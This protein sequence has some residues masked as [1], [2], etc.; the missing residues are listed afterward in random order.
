MGLSEL[1]VNVV[2]KQVFEQIRALELS[3]KWWF[4]GAVLALC[5]ALD[6]AALFYQHVLDLLPCELCIY[7]RVWLAALGLLALLAMYACR[8]PWPR[9]F[10]SLTAL[11]LAIGLA[12]ESWNLIVVEYGIG[13]GGSCGFVAN[14]PEWAPLD[15]W[16]PAVFEVQEFCQATPEILLGISM[17]EGLAAISLG[18]ILVFGFMTWESFNKARGVAS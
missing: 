14:F 16:F 10:L 15:N 4:W 5:L 1:W 2:I 6:G 7:T 12:N 11:A 18:L 13:G 3:S 8:W 17:A 9:V